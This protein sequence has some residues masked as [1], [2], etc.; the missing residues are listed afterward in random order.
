MKK[1]KLYLTALCL[2]QFML[3][4]S[5]TNLQ[6]NGILYISGGSDIVFISGAF[7]N[8]GTASLTNNGNLYVRQNLTNNQAGMPAGT[9]TLYLNGS[10]AQ[11]LGGTQTFR[12]NHLNTNN[13]NGIT[14][15]IN[16]S[17]AGIHTFANGIITTSATPNYLVYEAGSSYTGATDNRHVNGWVKKI[18]STNFTFPV[19]NGTYL[20]DISLSNLSAN[21]EFNCKHYLVTP[22]TTNVAA[23]VVLVDNFE[24]WDIPRVSGGTA[25]VTMNWDNSKISFPNYS[26]PEIRAVN[27]AAGLW[28]DRGGAASGNVT[29]T[30]VI[31]SNVVSNFGLYTFGSIN[32]TVP[33]RFLQFT[34]QRRQ[35][36]SQL[37]WSISRDVEA[38]RFEVERSDDAVN[39]R[40]I[41]TVAAAGGQF[42][43]QYNDHIPLLGKAWYRIRSIDKFNKPSYSSIALVNEAGNGEEKLYIVNNPVHQFIYVAAT[44]RFAGNYEYQLFNATGQLMQKGSINILG[45][46][47]SIPLSNAV[48]PG[49][50][51]VD[52]QNKQHRLS[53]KLVVR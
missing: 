40:K 42:K 50:Y 18:G 30:G 31:T 33:I 28:T 45:G 22:N 34:A 4:Q 27:Y 2:M 12:T 14:L 20:R 43:Y 47:A 6:N 44:G 49:V 52:L 16:L 10:I 36:Y 9:G 7:T 29:T 15:N 53:Q 19:G 46:F 38:D 23:P 17:V 3:A 11:T 5:Q 25:Q 24:Y 21:S 39:F 32:W 13:S 35:N 37:D 48:A 1:G 8:A 51:I 26:L 41:G